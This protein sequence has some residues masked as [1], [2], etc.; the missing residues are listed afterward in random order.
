MD[1]DDLAT[2][3]RPFSAEVWCH[4]PADRSFDLEALARDDDGRDRWSVPGLRTTYLAGD[5]A[6]AL[7]EYARHASAADPEARFLVRLRARGVAVLDV[8]RSEVACRLGIEDL[9]V[10]LDR[11]VTRGLTAR[12]RSRSAGWQ[13]LI[14]P[15]VAFLDDPQRWNLV[16]FCERLESLGSFLDSPRTA[17]R[18]ALEA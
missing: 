12:L 7:A 14:V 10:M 2:L 13:G 16:L 1:P 17:G 6:V 18:I 15:S 5:R 8:R 9:R 3:V 4:A 11:E